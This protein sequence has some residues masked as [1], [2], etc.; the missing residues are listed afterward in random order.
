MARP[1]QVSDEQILTVMRDQVLAQGPNVS[2]DLVAEQLKVSTPALLKRFGNR[3]ALMLA[4]LRPPENPEWMVRLERGPGAGSLEEQLL[5]IFTQISIYMSQAI[6]SI[7]ALRESGIPMEQVY[8]TRRGPEQGLKALQRW[9]LSARKAGLITAPETDTA[10]FAML[11][12]LQTRAFLS[13]LEQREFSVKAQ[14]GYLGE[15]SRLF[16]RALR[17]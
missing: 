6:P 2:L 10:A 9:L 8:P 7:C 1:R 3:R 17:P 15:L 4:A 12:A 13:H 11:G 14:R 16:T 5:D